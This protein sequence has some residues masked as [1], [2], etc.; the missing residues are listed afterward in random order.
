MAL[1]SQLLTHTLPLVS[2]HSFTRPALLTA[3]RSLKPEVTNHD[4]VLDTLFGPGSVGAT[5]ALV[6]AWETEGRARMGSEGE[7]NEDLAQVLM[8]RMDWSAGAGE[9]LVEA[10]ANLATPSSTLSIPF[11]ALGLLRLV[12]SSI[13]L[14]PAYTPPSLAPSSSSSSSSSFSPSRSPPTH[15]SST[16]D[17]LSA[18]AGYKLPLI[19]AN[20]LGP[21]GYAW[22]IA[23]EALYLTEQKGKA[24]GTV[25]RGYWNEPLGPGPEWYVKRMGLAA[26]YLSAESQLL[27]PYPTT[28]TTTTD[29]STS[30]TNPHL[31]AALRA[32]SSNLSRYTGAIAS[33]ERSEESLG[34]AAGFIDYV[35]RSWQGLIR[36]RYF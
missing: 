20:P 28:T 11:P 10:Y 6:E 32:L 31:P 12:L 9:H 30:S 25:K 8:R 19:A 36:S 24:V 13:R 29:G 21:L 22:R 15:P 35:A 26:V 16:I 1:R 23:D 27:K 18:A 5:K 3:L 14:P 33:I 34:D 7:A 4:A 2:T 17:Q